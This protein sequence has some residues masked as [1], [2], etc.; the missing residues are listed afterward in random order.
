MYLCGNFKKV[1]IWVLILELMCDAFFIFSFH[2]Q[3]SQVLVHLRY[4]RFY[5]P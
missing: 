1:K 2:F 4:S 3:S 5:V